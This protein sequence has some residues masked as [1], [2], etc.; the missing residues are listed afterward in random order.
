MRLTESEIQEL[1]ESMREADESNSD[2]PVGYFGTHDDDVYECGDDYQP[3]EYDEWQDF[4]G[5]DD[6]DQG[7]YDE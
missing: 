2:D 1:V 5:G 6:W 4:M 3:S 7:Q